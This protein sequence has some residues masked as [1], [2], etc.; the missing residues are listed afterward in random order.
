MREYI[1]FISHALKIISQIHH[2]FQ[3]CTKNY[4]ECITIKSSYDQV[5]IAKQLNMVYVKNISDS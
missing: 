5:F 1:S 3:F 4:Y 2:H